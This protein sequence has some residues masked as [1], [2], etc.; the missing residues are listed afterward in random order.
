MEQFK[1]T[2][3]AKAAAKQEAKENSRRRSEPSFNR[4]TR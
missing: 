2:K 1:K 3:S 4:A